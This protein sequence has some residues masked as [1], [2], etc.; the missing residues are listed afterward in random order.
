ML[1][2]AD[3]PTGNLDSQTGTQILELFHKLH[4]AGTTVIPVTPGLGVAVQ[5]QRMVHMIDGR[6]DVDRTV[7]EELRRTLVQDAISE[8]AVRGAPSLKRAAG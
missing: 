3:E 8:F 4:Q 6:I 1:L 5:T 2:L 7:T